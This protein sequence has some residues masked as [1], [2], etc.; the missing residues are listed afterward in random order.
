MGERFAGQCGRF[1]LTRH[2]VFQQQSGALF[3]RQPL[4]RAAATHFALVQQPRL[5]AAAVLR[6][7]TLLLR[8]SARLLGALSLL[9]RTL[10]LLFRTLSLLFRTLSLLLGTE[11]QLRRG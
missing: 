3:W 1:W 10:S 7:V 11:P 8:P 6:A 2:A 4:L 9:F 5:L